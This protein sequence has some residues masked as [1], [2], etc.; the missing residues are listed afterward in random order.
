MNSLDLDFDP[1]TGREVR[2]LRGMRTQDAIARL[3]GVH[4]G[5]WRSWEREGVTGSS[6]WSALLRILEEEDRDVSPLNCSIVAADA[7]ADLLGSYSALARSLKVSRRTVTRWRYRLGYVPGTY[8][9]GRLVRICYEDMA[10]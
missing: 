4:E 3:V 8:G 6:G 7:L 10:L 2:E 9:Y 1:W 5:Q